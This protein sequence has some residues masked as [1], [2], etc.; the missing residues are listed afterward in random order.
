MSRQPPLPPLPSLR[1]LR[2][3][4]T[5][6]HEGGFGSAAKRL[7]VTR[8]AVSHLLADL[9]R[10]LG[11]TL[12][13]RRPD[14]VRLTDEGY[15]LLSSLRDPIE[16]IESAIAGFRRDRGEVRL[17]TISSF[18]SLWLIPRLPAF[19][20]A[21][22]EV[23]VAVS[24]SV[25]VADFDRGEVDCAIRHGRGGWPGLDAALLFWESLVVVGRPAIIAG[26]AHGDFG[27]FLHE[28]RVIAVSTRPDDLRT[29]WQGTGLDG[30][31]PK[32]SLSVETRAQAVAGAL[33]GAGVALA[34][35]RLIRSDRQARELASLPLP[36]VALPTGYHFVVPSRARHRRPV[37]LLKQWVLAEAARDDDDAAQG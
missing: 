10:Q 5:V 36:P 6:A 37:Q 24:T 19:H 30:P 12:V 31:L 8:S 25:Q 35:P 18:A 13:E 34:D 22:P 28:T 11:V 3:F 29:W 26:A 15:S 20:A 33:A 4:T 9:E 14:G 2:A 27:R 23:R 7:G 21:R 16:R 1:A 17:S 32:P